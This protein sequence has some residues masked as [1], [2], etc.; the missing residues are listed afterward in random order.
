MYL[1][2]DNSTHMTVFLLWHANE[3][4]DGEEDSKFIGAYSTRALAEA[5]QNRVAQPPGFRDAPEGFTIDSHEV[6]RDEWREGFVT[7]HHG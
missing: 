6:D 7:V 1:D 2:A 4:P 5:A 3:L